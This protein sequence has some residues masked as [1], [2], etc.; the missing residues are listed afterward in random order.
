MKFEKSE[1]Q[2][3]NLAEFL[4]VNSKKLADAGD[5]ED[6]LKAIFK[7]MIVSL[8]YYNQTSIKVDFDGYQVIFTDQAGNLM[9]SFVLPENI[10]DLEKR[11]KLGE[12]KNLEEKFEE[13]GYEIDDS[14]KFR[15]AINRQLKK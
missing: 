4:E 15:D 12:R 10:I 1:Q 14:E 5:I 13:L 7:P 3:N 11:G 6:H 8:T 2:F 9:H